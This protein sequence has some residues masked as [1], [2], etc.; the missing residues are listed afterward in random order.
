MAR[1]VR[2]HALVARLAAVGAQVGDVLG[3]QRH[4]AGGQRRGVDALH[5]GMRVRGAH[6]RG[7][8]HPRPLDV[9]RVA[10]RAA[11]ARVDPG[12]AHASAS[13]ARRTST[14]TIRLR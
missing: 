6:E 11:Q 13:S 2:E 12:R 1:D 3:Q 8:P 10:L 14:A 7:V 9:H 5:A 4:A